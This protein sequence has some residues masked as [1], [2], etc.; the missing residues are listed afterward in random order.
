MIDKKAVFWFDLETSGLSRSKNA[1][2]EFAGL[3]EID[4][5]I[6]TTVHRFLSPEGYEVEPKAMEVNG[7][8][9]A[10]LI[11]TG[12]APKAFLEELKV[13]LAVYVNRWDPQDK[14]ICAGHN[15]IRFDRDF[16]WSV[17]KKEEVDFLGA[18]LD[19]VN[20][21]TLALAHL[22]RAQGLLKLSNYKLVTLA[23]HFGIKQVAAH[24]ALEDIMVTRDVYYK[25]MELLG[26]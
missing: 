24:T 22:C 19:T 9:A 3:V 23:E 14:F 5:E 10:E 1:I 7:L 13:I 20:I 4:G 18:Y 11:K 26:K 6:K 21:D 15:I 8:D 25:L 17:A 12:S 2:V 16:L